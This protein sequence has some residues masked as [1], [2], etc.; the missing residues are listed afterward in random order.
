[1]EVVDVTKSFGDVQALKGITLNIAAGEFFSLL[2]P[3]GCG[4]TTLLRMIAGLDAPTTG[5][6]TI[7]GKDM[8]G[9]P[10]HKRPVNL[11]F[12]SYALFPHMTVFDNVAFGLRV[13]KRCSQDEIPRRVHEA[14]ELVRL[15]NF[16]KRYPKELSGGQ[17]Q[18][19]AFARAIVNKPLVLLLDEPLSALDPR[20][21]EEM[22]TELA[23]FKRELGI[24][25]IM[26]THDQS[27]A[28]ALSDRVAVFNAGRLEQVGPP[29]AIYQQPKS[30]FVADFIGRTN[31]LAGTVGSIAGANVEVKI[32]EVLT[33]LGTAGDG[34]RFTAGQSAVVWIRTHDI[35]L[36]EEG[37]SVSNN[38]NQFAARILHRSYQGDGSD[39]VLDARG[40]QVV[41][42]VSAEL[43]EKF[44]VGDT[45]SVRIAAQ[46]VHVLDA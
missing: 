8:R 18:R 25:F 29:S 23:R 6:I 10:A 43:A 31:V 37:G 44:A 4:K 27:E 7:G 36:V 30:S 46:D 35:E 9:V 15:P 14:L 34:A 24:T 40:T 3:S 2:G 12:Q 16:A 28:F 38:Q 13:G 33:L 21:R 20:I 5:S 41:A 11:V 42:R 19:I 22:Q 26:V 32:S 45:V 39:C 17:Q 1:V